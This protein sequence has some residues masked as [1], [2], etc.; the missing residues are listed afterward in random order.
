MPKRP[1]AFQLPPLTSFDVVA[2]NELA[3][4]LSV[5]R[6]ASQK[7]SDSPIKSAGSSKKEGE[8]T[9]GVHP[10]IAALKPS[11]FSMDRDRGYFTPLHV[12]CA[13]GHLEIVRTLLEND[14]LSANVDINAV[15]DQNVTPL[16]CAAFNGHADVVRLLLDKG[17]N[18]MV[19]DANNDL[20]MH[21]ARRNQH[22]T[23]VVALEPSYFRD[24]DPTRNPIEAL[25]TG[26]LLHFQ[27]CA[28]LSRDEIIQ[29]GDRSHSTGADEEGTVLGPLHPKHSGSITSRMSFAADAE[30]NSLLHLVA[31]QPGP[32][33]P[34]LLRI[35][36]LVLQHQWYSSIDS[37]NQ[38]GMT[39][40]HIAAESNNYP[41]IEILLRFGANALA[42]IEGRED[43]TALTLST[44][45]D[46]R[47]LLRLATLKAQLTVMLAGKNRVP[48]ENRPEFVSKAKQ[49]KREII[50]AARVVDS[51]SYDVAPEDNA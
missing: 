35:A 37:K 12:A 25:N 42:T 44:A 17:A 8:E 28:S 26:D 1:K 47:A 3:A 6:I 7:T 39:P 24:F 13:H 32:L 38:S 31:L 36:E 40:L 5:L 46:S 27:L 33:S 50:A 10:A 14:A 41:L 29:R 21:L 20:P 16:H 30:E 48:V 15:S 19:A 11:N 4:L 49:L 22:S 23:I 9:V 2:N 45:A 51:K 43:S 34:A 18:P